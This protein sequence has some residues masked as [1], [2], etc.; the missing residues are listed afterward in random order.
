MPIE[1]TFSNHEKNVIK[2][3]DVFGVFASNLSVL[4]QFLTEKGFEG[5]FVITTTTFRKGY[6]L[7]FNVV[8]ITFPSNE[9]YMVKFNSFKIVEAIEMPPPFH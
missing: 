9:V 3:N 6:P 4:R 7:D 8:R 5:N 1:F 2:N